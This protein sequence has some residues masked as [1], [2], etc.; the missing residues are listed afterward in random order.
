MIKPEQNA[1]NPEPKTSSS[2]FP[3]F[4]R[5]LRAVFSRKML[6]AFVI[7]ITL[8]ALG[9][10]VEN[11]R[12]ARAWENY[13]RAAEAR[14]VKLD[15][16]AYLPP[17]VPDAENGANTPWVQSWFPKSR[18]FD[19]D[20]FWPPLRTLAEKMISTAKPDGR[21]HLTDLV[22]WKEALEFASTNSSKESSRKFAAHERNPAERAAAAGAVLEYLKVYEATL[23][24]LRAASTRPRIRYPVDYRLDE[25]F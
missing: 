23:D 12:G 5:C 7:L 24:E 9:Y 2:R 16:A 1:M 19:Q 15:F 14:G 11:F 6:Y 10:A 20:N 21:R 13:R 3:F 25:P 8:V 18:P 22:A 4:R 17:P